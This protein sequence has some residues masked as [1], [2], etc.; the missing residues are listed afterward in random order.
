M[1]FSLAFQIYNKE[2]WIAEMVE[3]WL[4]T[5]SGKNEVE[6]IMVFDDLH[7]NSDKI[8]KNVLDR[9]RIPYQF[10]YADNVYE[11]RCNN[12]AAQIAS[13]DY[14]I[15]IQDDN[16]IYDRNWDETFVQVISGIENVG[17]VGLLAGI[18]LDKKF[19]HRRIEINR[20]HKK[21]MFWIDDVFD[22]GVWE[23]D[24]A[25]RPFAVS[26][27]V[28]EEVGGLDEKFCP[29][30]WDDLD[31]GM[32]LAQR[33]YHNIYI[34]FDVYNISTKTETIPKEQLEKSYGTNHAECVRRYGFYIRDRETTRLRKLLPLREVGGTISE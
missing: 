26:L 3:T 4:K 17:Q 27:S 19:H 1:K 9:Y 13:G 33:G 32:R 12:M 18:E 7:D 5:L 30:D 14:I 34:P 10:L 29:M 28:L 2:R 31:L 22:L 20:P 23:I 16:W 11:I 24:S 25:I 8:A 15:F 21:E 6:A